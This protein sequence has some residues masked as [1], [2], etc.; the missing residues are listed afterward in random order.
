[1]PGRNPGSTNTVEALDKVFDDQFRSNR[2][3][4]TGVTNAALVITD[5]DPSTNSDALEAAGLK[6]SY[7]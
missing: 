5:G 2:G 6:V 4:R 3:D 1:M 7:R